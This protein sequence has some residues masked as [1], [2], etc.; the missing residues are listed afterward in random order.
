MLSKEKTFKKKLIKTGMNILF[1]CSV[2]CWLVF[3]QLQ[4]YIY[5]LIC[6]TPIVLA[7]PISSVLFVSLFDDDVTA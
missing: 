6:P 4:I 1:I 3:V 5:F 2:E 7:S